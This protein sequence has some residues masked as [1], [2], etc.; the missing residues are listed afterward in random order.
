MKA[1]IVITAVIM[2]AAALAG[3]VAAYKAG[4]LRRAYLADVS[5]GLRRTRSTPAEPLTEEDIEHLP[6]PVRRY[7]EY[8]GAVG[9]PKVVSMRATFE[10]EMRGRDRDWFDLTAEQHNFFDRHER[11]FYLDARVNGLPTRGYHRYRD[12][13]ASMTIKLLGL[14]PVVDIEGDMMFDAETVTM[15]NDMCFLAPATLIDRSIKWEE[16]GPRS[17]RAGFTNLSSTISA[18][19]YFNEAGQLVNFV[20]DDR[21]DVNEGKRYRFSTP[22]GEFA[23][24]GGFNLPTYGEAVWHY[25]DGEFV[26]G[27]YRVRGIEYNVRDR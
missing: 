19:L 11:L 9:R 17:V 4:G 1:P 23:E 7:L 15:F 8:V 14:L 16:L 25:P 13:E 22:I 20:S 24:I 21:Y 6:G 3:A 27:R 26:Y 2:G 12:G 10:A 18:V 5:E